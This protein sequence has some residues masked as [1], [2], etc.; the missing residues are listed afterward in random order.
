MGQNSLLAN[1]LKKQNFLLATGIEGTRHVHRPK[2]KA[3]QT[4][5]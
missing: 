2:Q 3:F 1:T 5:F 4:A